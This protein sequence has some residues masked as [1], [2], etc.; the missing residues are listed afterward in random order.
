MHPVT[1][2][3]PTRPHSHTLRDHTIEPAPQEPVTSHR[4]GPHPHAVD[5]VVPHR[6]PLHTP[7]DPTLTPHTLLYHLLPSGGTPPSQFVGPHPRTPHPTPNPRTPRDPTFA[8]RG[9]PPSHPGRRPVGPHP[10][11]PWTSPC[12]TP[13]SHLVGPHPC[14][15]QGLTLRHPQDP[16]IP[17]EPTL[18]RSTSSRRRSTGPH[19]HT[20]PS[21]HRIPRS[22]R[23]T[24][25]CTSR[26]QA[27]TPHPCALLDL[28]PR[29]TP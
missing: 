15:P 18:M 8:P 14:T 28:A 20:L 4:V 10:P 22:H 11:T 25:K 9:A 29:G 16:C 21:H 6:T 24:P 13:S 7:Q 1:P 19:P 26:D 2:V 3:H 5:D 23:W 27:M 12:G 17:R